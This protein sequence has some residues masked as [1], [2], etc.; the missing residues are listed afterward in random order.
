MYKSTLIATALV[1]ALATGNAFA[2]AHAPQANIHTITI[3]GS[4]IYTDSKGMSLYTFDKDT[5]GVS[6]C[7]DGCAVKWPPLMA[8]GAAEGK[9]QFSVITRADGT[10]QWAVNG[11]ALYT[12]FKDKKSGDT[13]GDGVKGVWHIA[14]P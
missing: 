10:K 13:T 3:D 6:N 9:G 1:T 2:A 5:K 7:N 8:V 12:W 4:K 11:M 14:K